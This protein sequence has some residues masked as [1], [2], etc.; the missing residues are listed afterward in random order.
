MAVR[1]AYRI[2]P[3]IHVDERGG[4]FESFRSGLFSEVTGH[5]FVPVQTNFSINHRNVL[6]GMHGVALPPGQ[7]KYVTC[8]RGAVKDVVLDV[9][10][11]SPTFGC[12]DVNVLEPET[13]VA[14]FI[15]DGMAH[16]FISLADDS[17]VSYVFDTPYMPGTPFEIHP[18][19]ADLELPWE[20]TTDLIVAAKDLE[21]PTL[22]QA[23]GMGILP[24]YEACLAHY[25]RQADPAAVTPL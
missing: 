1:D 12:Y 21:A 8:V 3:R 18:F 17:C 9:R 11:G 23:A 4:F 25:A 13:G 15:P 7:A 22:S 2:R 14:V 6:R 5:R 24:T 20:R 19:D 10:V 16:G